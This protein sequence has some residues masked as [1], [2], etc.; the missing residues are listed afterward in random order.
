MLTT[1]LTID[2]YLKDK[3]VIIDEALNTFLP[4]EETYPQLI[5]KSMRYSA[6]AGGKRFRPALVLAAI[7][8]CGG[9]IKDGLATACAISVSI[10][11]L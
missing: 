6:L 11:I 7:E 9:H 2:Q 1:E 4:Q 10:R 8:A 5:H 3:S